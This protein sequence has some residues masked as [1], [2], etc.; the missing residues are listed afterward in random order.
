MGYSSVLCSLGKVKY[1][2]LLC[3][4]V[5]HAKVENCIGKVRSRI[6]SIGIVKSSY[7]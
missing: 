1:S 4:I 5:L 6:V 2:A 7:A 3:F